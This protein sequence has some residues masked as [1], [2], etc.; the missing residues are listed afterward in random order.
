MIFNQSNKHI[1]LISYDFKTT[2]SIEVTG[3]IRLPYRQWI[4]EDPINH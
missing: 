4:L 2:Y 1:N 3:S